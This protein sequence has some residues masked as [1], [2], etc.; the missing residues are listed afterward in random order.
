MEQFK[1]IIHGLLFPHLAVVLLSI[2]AAAALLI[3]TFA[4]AGESSPVAYPSYVLSAYS[5]TISCAWLGK[6]GRSMKARIQTAVHT[7]PVS[8]R[9]ITDVSFRMQVSLHLSLGMNVLYA[10]MKFVYGLL[11]HSIWYGTL[12]V[13]YFLL[14]LMRFALLRSANRNGFGK[15]ML[16]ELKQYRFCGMILL[17]MNIALAGVVVLVV[18]KNEG[19][20]Y[21]GYLIYVMALYAFINIT[22]AV[23]NVVRYRKYNS[24]V[25]SAAKVLSFTSA[26]VSML[27]L[28]TAMLAQFGAEENPETFRR[29]MTAA[30][31]GGVCVIVF[32]IAVCMIIH[33][34]R[35]RKR[36]EE[37]T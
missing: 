27:S 31:G 23:I 36:L 24:P 10:V 25:M 8:H 30:T 29:F 37:R 2:P 12:A 5:L 4:F 3:C 33:S 28:E 34:G 26:L 32:A 7:N 13:Y 21:A 20:R 6:N 1:R 18:R 35:Q 19:F 14:A 22:T 11:Y 17:V 15:N 9:Y 16:Q